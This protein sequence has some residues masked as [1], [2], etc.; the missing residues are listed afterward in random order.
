MILYWY[1]T[2]R[3]FYD[4]NIEEKNIQ[5]E[6]VILPESSYMASDGSFFL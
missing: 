6:K 5:K 3:Y 2:L 1:I 4:Y